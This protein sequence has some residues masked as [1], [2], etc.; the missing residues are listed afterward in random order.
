MVGGVRPAVARTGPRGFR[1][2]IDMRGVKTAAAEWELDL[3]RRALVLRGIA[4]HA[5]LRVALGAAVVPAEASSVFDRKSATLTVTVPCVREE[6]EA[7]GAS[8][9]THQRATIDAVEQAEGEAAEKGRQTAAP[10]ELLAGEGALAA[11]S[12]N[13]GAVLAAVPVEG[14]P[15]AAAL[16]GVR[17]SQRDTE[18]TVVCRWR[19]RAAAATSPWRTGRWWWARRGCCWAGLW[20]RSQR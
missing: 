18:V 8:A 1:V 5:D 10:V 7:K 15:A 12:E 13:E 4:P 14:A 19:S 3:E 17:C 11:Q 20:R 16:K 9:E 6:E 2:A